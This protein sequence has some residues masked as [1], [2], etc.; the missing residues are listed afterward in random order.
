MDTL[1]KVVQA[2]HRAVLSNYDKLYLD[3]GTGNWITGGASWC[4]PYKSW[5]DV[6]GN[7]PLADHTLTK[8]EQALVLGGEV[9]LWGESIDATNIDQKAWPRGCAHAERMWSPRAELGVTWTNATHRLLV[10]RER[11]VA[12]GISVNQIMPRYCLQNPGGCPAP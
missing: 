6:W 3:C 5:Q 8:D 7:E 11:M 12:R 1:T 10:H 2:G 9:A 4:A